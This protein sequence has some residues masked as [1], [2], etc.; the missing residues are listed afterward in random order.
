MTGE[1]RPPAERRPAAEAPGWL[2][3]SG[4]TPRARRMLLL[5]LVPA[6]VLAGTLRYDFVFDDNIVVLRDSLVT[7]HLGL[8]EIF[9][10]EVRVGEVIMGYYRPVISLSYWADRAVWG[11]NPA[12]FHLTNL[13]WHLLATILVYVVALRTTRHVPGAWAAAMLFGVLPA[14]TEAIGWIQGRTD[15]ISTALLLL[16]LLALLRSQGSAG[17][18]AWSWGGLGGFVFLVALLAKESVSPLPLAW[19]AWEISATEADPW[20]KRLAGLSSRFVPLLIAG[21]AYWVLRRWVVGE[22]VGFPMSLT[23]LGL[24]ALALLSVLAEYG[25]VLLFP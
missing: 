4:R 3:G 2:F 20:R 10:N 24:R 6:L 25:R 18:T 21:L 13:L 1:D 15:L 14:H 22:L 16:A 5:V 19:T 23:P 7:G 11:L 12:G 9:G 8:R 17:W